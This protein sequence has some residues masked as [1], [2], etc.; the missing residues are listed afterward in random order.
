MSRTHRWLSDPRQYTC[1]MDLV[2]QVGPGACPKCGMALEPVSLAP[3]TKTEWTCPLH[4]EV[5]QGGPGSCPICGMAL[6]PRIVTLEEDN[7]EL[8]DMSRRFWWSLA[9]TV[10]VLAFMGSEFLPGQPLQRAMPPARFRRALETCWR[11]HS[12]STGPQK[13]DNDKSHDFSW[14]LRDCVL[15][16]GAGFEPATFGL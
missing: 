3:V 11:R 15:V 7:Q 8:T 4:P 16:A 13:P 14:L 5:V 1:P 12:S 10:P 9:L 6:E 2:R